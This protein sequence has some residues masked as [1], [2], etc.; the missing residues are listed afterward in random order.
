M[1]RVQGDQRER[2]GLDPPNDLAARLGRDFGLPHVAPPDQDARV[3]EV[4]GWQPLLGIVEFDR[5][6]GELW[7]V[8]KIRGDLVAQE[9]FIRLFLRGLLFVPDQDVDLCGSRRAYGLRAFRGPS[10]SP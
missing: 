9:V 10:L 3:V 6:N 7:L 4:G 1:R 2:T 8:A 5:L